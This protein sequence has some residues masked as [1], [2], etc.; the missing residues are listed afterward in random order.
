MPYNA[1]AFAV[2]GGVAG[3]AAGTI[4]GLVLSLRANR[5]S[6]GPPRPPRIPYPEFRSAY[7]KKWRAAHG[8]VPGLLTPHELALPAAPREV[9]GDVAVF[10]FDRA[11]VTERW[12]TAAMLVANRFHFEHNCAVL[13]HDGFP[14]DIADTVKTMLRRNP[15]LTLFALHDASPDG[16]LLPLLL[17]DEG[18]FPDT[19]VRIVDVGLRPA[20]VRQLGLPAIHL[21]S[22]QDHPSLAEVL[23]PEDVAWLAHGNVAELAALRPAQVMR[24]LHNA[25]AAVAAADAN[26][27]SLDSGGG[28]GGF[29]IIPIGT[30]GGGGADPASTDGFG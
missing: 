14:G 9:A 21:L 16:C 3:L 7:L 29:F 19:S 25:I 6:P 11:V 2:M 22:G 30:G 18:W 13:S 26:G 1:G 27:T 10:S 17:R 8:D 4:A 20:M 28:G 5:R 24:A 12:E 23:P 15:D